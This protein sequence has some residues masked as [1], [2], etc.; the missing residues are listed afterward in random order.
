MRG[1]LREVQQMQDIS[2]SPFLSGTDTAIAEYRLE[3]HLEKLRADRHLEMSYVVDN[4]I[5]HGEL[6]GSQFLADKPSPDL[7]QWQAGSLGDY[8]RRSGVI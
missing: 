8:L 1:E 5:L 6:G 3:R 2:E 7:S 4:S